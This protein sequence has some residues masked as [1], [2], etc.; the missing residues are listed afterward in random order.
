[1]IIPDILCPYACVPLGGFFALSAFICCGSM[2]FAQDGA[3]SEGVGCMPTRQADADKMHQENLKKYA[4][5]DEVLVL[6]GLVA[7][8]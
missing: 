4:G 7:K 3:P 8:R 2:A 1:M 5:N 6:P